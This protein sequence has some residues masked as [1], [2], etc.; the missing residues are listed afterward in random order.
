MSIKYVCKY[1]KTNMGEIH[2][3]QVSEMQLGFH[4]LTPE[5]RK[6]IIAYNPNGEIMVNITCDHC[7]EIFVSHPELALLSNPLQ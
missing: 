5:E 2:S 4:S 1:C 3:D 7:H 6:D